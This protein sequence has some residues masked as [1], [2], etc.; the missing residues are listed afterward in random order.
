MQLFFFAWNA[1]ESEQ[2]KQKKQT[3]IVIVECAFIT[4]FNEEKATL[5][6]KF[7]WIFRRLWVNSQLAHKRREF[8][9][10]CMEESLLKSPEGFPMAFLEETLIKFLEE[11]PKNPLE[12]ISKKSLKKF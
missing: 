6:R 8:P 9:K 5:G 2:V 1:Y 4:T 12:K 3:E 11:F 7:F 10:E